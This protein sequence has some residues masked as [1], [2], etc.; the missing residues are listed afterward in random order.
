MVLPRSS[1]KALSLASKIYTYALG[2]KINLA[3][4]I[5]KWLS[6][7]QTLSINMPLFFQSVDG[8]PISV[9]GLMSRYLLYKEPYREDGARGSQPASFLPV[10]HAHT[11]CSFSV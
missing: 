3:Y 4:L 11:H 9:G 2:P 5:S 8:H 1:N 6:I 10:P 7:S